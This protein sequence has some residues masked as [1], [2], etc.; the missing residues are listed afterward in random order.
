MQGSD[1]TESAARQ[2]IVQAKAR[3]ELSTWRFI[4]VNIN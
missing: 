3:N 4:A 2:H 1:S